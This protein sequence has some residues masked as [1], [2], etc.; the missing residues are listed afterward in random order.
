[1]NPTLIVAAATIAVLV[2]A[3]RVLL[4]MEARGWIY[5]R[6]RSA[7]PRTGPYDGVPH[8]GIQSI[9][10]VFEPGRMTPLPATATDEE[11]IAFIDEWAELLEQEDYEAAFA[12]TDHVPG[13]RW[14]PE[15]IR[16]AIRSHGPAD[17][18]QRVTLHGVPIETT[19]RKEV[20]HW[21]TSPNGCFGEVWYGLNIDGRATD[22]TATFVL[23]QVEGGIAVLLDDIH[24][25]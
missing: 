24:A 19:Q 10:P 14:T 6:R 12:F 11:L 3:D 16:D 17:P 4:G 2:V 1:M 23:Q 8:L 20:D 9:E 21:T 25:M 13:T 22:L 15:L 18:D 5:Y 7:S